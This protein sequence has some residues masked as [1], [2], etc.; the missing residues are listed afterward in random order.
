MAREKIFRLICIHLL[1]RLSSGQDSGAC[2]NQTVHDFWH[3]SMA[4]CE[5]DVRSAFGVY[6]K[7][8]KSD[9]PGD[10]DQFSALLK[11]Q[12]AHSLS[13]A[14][15]QEI[16]DAISNG[17]LK[18]AVN[19]EMIESEL[20]KSD[21]VLARAIWENA[22]Q[23]LLQREIEVPHIMEQVLSLTNG[24][25]KF[26]IIEHFWRRYEADFKHNSQFLPIIS[27]AIVSLLQQCSGLT[28]LQAINAEAIL[29]Q[30]P[31]QLVELY[32][33]SSYNVSFINRHHN[34]YMYADLNKGPTPQK[35]LVFTFTP[36]PHTLKIR[37]KFKLHFNNRGMVSMHIFMKDGQRAIKSD[38][39][40]VYYCPN[41]SDSGVSPQLWTIL[42]PF[43]NLRANGEEQYFY[44]QHSGNGNLLCATSAYDSNRRW[45]QVLR[46]SDYATMETC[47]WKVE[48][49]ER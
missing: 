39:E 42:W 38:D 34:E 23:E 1:F 10:D 49:K 32:Q 21:N 15:V 13:E 36:T 29:R 19:L 7:L 9:S 24:K 47:Q 17:I 12:I 41:C 16:V 44:L 18:N 35:R 25:F 28:T 20:H 30:L 43:E 3:E 46:V 40:S 26:A 45:L 8:S 6:D 11:Y 5:M 33:S 4:P 14:L 48:K 37:G 27:Y 2:T 31:Q 22:L